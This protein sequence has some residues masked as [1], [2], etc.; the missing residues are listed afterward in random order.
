MEDITFNGFGFDDN[1]V[2]LTVECM[3]YHG[4]H[5][6]RHTYNVEKEISCNVQQVIR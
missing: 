2:F 5:R 4:H 3:R 6:R 1:K